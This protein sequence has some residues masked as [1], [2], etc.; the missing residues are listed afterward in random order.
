MRPIRLRV[1]ERILIGFFAYIA[2]LTPLFRERPHL[3]AQPWVL[4]AAVTALFCS[5]S[6]WE[7]GRW[8]RVI[9]IARDWLPLGLT[10]VAF[11]EMEFFLP[12]DYNYG[13]ELAWIHWDRV[14]L[15]DWGLRHAI[16]SLGKTL[17]FYFEF[18]YLLVYGVGA[19]GVGLL[20][21]G[22]CERTARRQ[23]IDRF[24]IMYLA[25]TLGA[26][27]LFPYF[28]TQPPRY[29]FPAVEPP[30]VSTWV[31]HFNLFLLGRATI[32]VGVFP[33]AHVSSAFSSA[34]GTFL[35]KPRRRA[36]GRILLV[37]AASVAIATVYGRYH[38]AVDALA[39]LG[40]SV[41]SG[42]VAG[43]YLKTCG[44]TGEWRRVF[45]LLSRPRR[46]SE[47]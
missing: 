24:W 4:L 16:E 22:S 44:R 20:S 33:S 14:V 15:G 1:P 47:T 42:A 3:G 25:G 40:V 34:W 28:P 18:C 13:Y 12:R 8:Q 21:A 7:R 27:A 11:R 41:V 43:V 17:P 30:L 2:L 31:R 45:S 23:S 19:Y 38:Y 32:H 46:N 35:A 37:Y 6:F 26:Y 29:V 10:F 5:L 39:G 9:D 36:W